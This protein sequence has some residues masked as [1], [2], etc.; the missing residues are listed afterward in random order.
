MASRSWSM[1]AC[2]SH[3]RPVTMTSMATRFAA[4]APYPHLGRGEPA[5]VG[6]GG[7][8][9]DTPRLERRLRAGQDGVGQPP[10]APHRGTRVTMYS[11]LCF[12]AMRVGMR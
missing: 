1:P 4:G 9:D 12:G 2:P 5:A 8:P 6:G 10:S 11:H 3:V 7:E